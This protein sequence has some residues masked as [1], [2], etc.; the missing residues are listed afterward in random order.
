MMLMIG[1]IPSLKRTKS[2][3]RPVA[4]FPREEKDEVWHGF[5]GVFSSIFIH[6]VHI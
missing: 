1:G 3:P 6:A 4:S 5:E 2:R